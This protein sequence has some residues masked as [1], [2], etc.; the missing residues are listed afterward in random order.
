MKKF[1]MCLNYAGL[2]LGKFFIIGEKQEKPKSILE[3]IKC[4]FMDFL[5]I[6]PEGKN[7]K[8]ASK[9]VATLDQYHK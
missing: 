8:D 9:L 5:R 3:N 6:I 1:G 2:G 4:L 7:N